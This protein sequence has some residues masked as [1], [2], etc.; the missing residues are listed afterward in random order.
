MSWIL[1]QT[2]G[3]PHLWPSQQPYEGGTKECKI[4]EGWWT[5]TKLR[6]CQ[7]WSFKIISKPV[8]E[9]FTSRH[10][11]SSLRSHNCSDKQSGAWGSGCL[12]PGLGYHLL[13]QTKRPSLL[14]N[15]EVLPLQM[16][17][18]EKVVWK[19]DQGRHMCGESGGGIAVG[20]PFPPVISGWGER[21]HGLS[22]AGKASAARN[23]SRC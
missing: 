9:H 12:F 7:I 6:Y 21:E 1:N 15:K 10:Y 16:I 4:Q 8:I 19:R 11:M 3:M 14:Q 5:A 2:L 13:A 22:W 18:G 17:A 20:H 23:V